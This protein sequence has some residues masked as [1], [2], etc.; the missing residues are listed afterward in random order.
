MY[1]KLQAMVYSA[2]A[3]ALMISLSV[4]SMGCAA[5]S[6]AESTPAS[7][8]PVTVSS[9]D[10]A[11][12]SE[13][14]Q[15]PELND[16]A[17]SLPI[18][19]TAL[20]AGEVIELEVAQTPDQQAL[21]LMYRTSLP[22]DRGML[23]PFDRPRFTRFWMRNVEISLDMIFLAGDEVVAIAQ[24][25]PPCREAVCPTYGPDT[26]VTQVIELRGGRAEELGLEVGDRISITPVP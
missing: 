3:I 18:T 7:K 13:T 24:D 20:I 4:M 16:Q 17:Q 26:Q 21:G 8:P 6:T 11:P 23:F 14:S 22:D 5:P 9:P 15:S 12:P 2:S 10:T 19:A 1:L 25:V